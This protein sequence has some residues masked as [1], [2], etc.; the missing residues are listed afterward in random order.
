MVT[1]DGMKAVKEYYEELDSE[2]V[3]VLND[4][5]VLDAVICNTGRHFG[6]FGFLV[7]NRT[8][9][10]VAPAPLFDHGNSLFNYFG[11]DDLASA[12]TLAA[13]AET[14]LPCAYDDFMGTA[15]A[16]LT[17]EHKEGF[18]HLLEFRFKRHTRYNLPPKHLNLIEKQ[19][20]KRAKILLEK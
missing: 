13:Y 10:I 19:V 18:R 8:N 3:K 9:K 7:D 16:A 6:N 11:A 20:R 5:F 15:K 14:L 4:M 17:P 2:Y 1:S 12:E